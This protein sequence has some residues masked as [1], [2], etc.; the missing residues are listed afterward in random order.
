MTEASFMKGALSQIV[1]VD[2]SAHK[3]AVVGWPAI[4]AMMLMNDDESCQAGTE[5]EFSST[6]L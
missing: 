1:E 4:S 5:S 6:Q 2:G 3:C